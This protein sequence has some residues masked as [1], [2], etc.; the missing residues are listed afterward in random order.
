VSHRSGTLW[1]KKG[2]PSSGS[3]I[4]ININASLPRARRRYINIHLLFCTPKQTALPNH[5]GQHSY[6]YDQRN[7]PN[8]AARRTISFVRHNKVPSEIKV[9]IGIETCNL[10]TIT[11]SSLYFKLLG[12]Q[13]R[14]QN[15]NVFVRIGPGKYKS[16]YFFYET[17]IITL[18]AR[19]AQFCP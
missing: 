1:D 14:R 7:R 9:S 15:R 10:N 11:P 19:A 4:H 18:V 5:K 6:N 2:R 8:R 16:F 17:T 3:P 12:N 13:E